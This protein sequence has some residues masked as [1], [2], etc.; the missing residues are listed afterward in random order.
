M[1]GIDAI[2][3]YNI[4]SMVPHGGQ[5]SFAEISERSGLDKGLVRRLLRH[6]MSMRIFREPEPEMVAHTKIS[7]FLSIPYINAWASF[8]GR[9]TWPAATRVSAQHSSSLLSDV[10]FI[11]TRMICHRSWTR[12]RNGLVPKNPTKL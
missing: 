7:S 9:D 3:R 11:L 2:S 1:V 4:A 8:E 10:A 6:A 5:I 12:S